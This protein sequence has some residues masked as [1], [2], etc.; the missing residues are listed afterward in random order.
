M[1]RRY[2]LLFLC[3]PGNPTGRFYTLEEVGALQRLC[4]QYRTFLVI[5]EAFMDFYEEGSAKQ[6]LSREETVLILR[7]MTKFYGFP[8][9][10]LGYAFGAAAVIEELES[11]CP[12]WSVG[13]LAQAAG[14]AALADLT[15]ADGTRCLVAIERE[16]LA[17]WL[18]EIGPLR[19]Y[20]GTANYLLVEIT[21]RLTATELQRR[22]MERRILIR[23]CSN[24]IGLDERFFRVAVRSRKE[25]DRLV[26]G[27]ASSLE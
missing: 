26:A 25:N 22:L 19:V 1:A 21:A 3:N 23:N 18:Q 4:R 5:D 10:R 14:M 11:L 9:L 8:G 20:P 13:T 15:H 12:P 17:A 24:F 2:D 6:L 7:S 16:R 27:I